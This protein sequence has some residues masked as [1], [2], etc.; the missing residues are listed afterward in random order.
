MLRIRRVFDANLPVD[1]RAVA[2]V[3]DILRARF[4]AV[5]EREVRALPKRLV[6]PLRHGFRTVLLVAE[7]PKGMAAP[8]RG[9]AKVLHFPDLAFCWLDYMAATPGKAGGGIGAALYQRVQ[10]ETASL[11]CLGLFFESLPAE[12]AV[13]REA[14]LLAENRRRLSFYARYGVRIV[15]GTAYELPLDADEKNPCPPHLLFDDLGSGEPLGREQAKNIVRA[16]LTRKYARKCSPQYVQAVVDSFADDPVQLVP[17][18]GSGRAIMPKPPAGQS[19]VVALAVSEQHH[20]HHVH[21]RGYVEAP[22]RISA[23]LET[24]QPSGLFTRIPVR[25]RSEDHILAVHDRGF[26]SYLKKACAKLPEEQ[27]IYPYVFPIRNAARPPKE[28]AVRAG[29]YCIDTFTPLNENA[30]RAAKAAVDTALAGADA[31]LSGQRL[32]YAL[33]RPPGHHAEHRAFGGFCYFNNT[34]VAAHYLSRHGKVA[35]LDVDYHHG[36]G[37]QDIFYERADVLT[38]SIHGR[39]DLAY[40]YFSGF[41]DEHGSG[42]GT[43]CNRNYPLADNIDGPAYRKVLEKALHVIQRFKPMVLVVAL[44]LDPA[45]GDP[46]GSWLLTAGDFAANGRLIG[47]LG[48]PTLVVQEGGYLIPSLGENAL[49]FFQGLV[50]AVHGSQAAPQK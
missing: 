41:E 36:N 39:P 18:P 44:G 16:V 21:E 19:G 7:G 26:F 50:Q 33:V 47:Q 28:L 2:Q 3:Q 23:V 45:K 31:V 4:P 8:V 10:Q 25:H 32:A 24:I 43:D 40:P 13:C 1:Q 5:S 11:D 6:D 34:A 46:T 29:Y 9:F 15:S 27:S 42:P 49:A 12:A 17:C 48:L 30:F 22:V 38:V 37:T 14:E 20:I 35:V